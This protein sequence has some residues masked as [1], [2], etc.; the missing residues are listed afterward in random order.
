MKQ[1]SN[2]SAYFS[3][4]ETGQTPQNDVMFKYKDLS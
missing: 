3:E 2:G 1:H 4:P